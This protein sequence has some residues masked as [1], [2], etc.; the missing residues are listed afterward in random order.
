M[1]SSFKVPQGRTFQV[2]KTTYKDNA[3]TLGFVETKH[4]KLKQ[5]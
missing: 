1:S 3:E 5:D 2:K 4:V